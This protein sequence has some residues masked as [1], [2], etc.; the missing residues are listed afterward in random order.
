MPIWESTYLNGFGKNAQYVRFIGRKKMNKKLVSL[1]LTGVTAFTMAACGST[2]T[3][4]TAA[5]T[6]AAAAATSAAAAATSDSAAAASTTEEAA[7][8]AATSSSAFSVDTAAEDE[9]TLIGGMHGMQTSISRLL[10]DAEAD[11]QKNVD[12][13]FNLEHHRTGLRSHPI[14]RL[15]SHLQLLLVTTAHFLI[16]YC[17]R[18][19]ISTNTSRIIRMH[20]SQMSMMLM[21]TGM[22][23]ELRKAFIFSML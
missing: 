6:S 21:L 17:S 5:A 12:P 11:Y 13:N 4:T 9:H 2:S 22:I 8:A 23:S 18:I 20:S 15:Q 1:V 10:K 14:L 7:A 3:D 16:S 19:T